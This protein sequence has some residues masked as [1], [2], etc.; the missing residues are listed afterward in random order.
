MREEA[1]RACAGL[2]AVVLALCSAGG[3]HIDLEADWHWELLLLPL[4]QLQ[5]PRHLIILD[6]HLCDD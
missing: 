3:L 1:W 6:E 2:L 4:Q 5:Q